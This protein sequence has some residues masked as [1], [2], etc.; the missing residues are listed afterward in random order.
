V[1][2]IDL[3]PS[4][5]GYKKIVIHPRPGKGLTYAKAGYRSICGQIQSGWKIEGNKFTLDVVIPVNTTAL[6]HVP[7]DEG[8]PILESGMPVEKSEG[9]LPS[10]KG[11]REALY[12]IGSGIYRF[13]STLTI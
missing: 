1:A 8:T 13:E 5:P 4:V 12:K 6:V 2:G 10:G 3:D 9:I 7:C 11:E